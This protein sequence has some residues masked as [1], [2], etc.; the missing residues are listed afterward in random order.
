MHK[1]HNSCMFF[2]APAIYNG[3]GHIASPLSVRPSVRTYVRTYEKW[4]PGDI[5]W[6]HWCIGFIF[7]TQVYKH[8]IQVKFD[9]GQNPL[10]IIRVM[11]L[12]LRMKNGF[13]AI[14]F[15]YIDVLDSYYI[16]RYISIKYRSSSIMGKIHQSLSELWPLIS[17]KKNGFQAISFEYIG[18]LDSYFIH[19]YI[20]IEHRSSL[21][22]DKIHLLLSELWPLISI[23]KMV[24]G[25]YLLNTLV[26]WIHNSYTGI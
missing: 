23:W 5:F 10:I 3:G 8:K 25:R 26:Y 17:V 15:E 18:E 2:Y 22:M 12:D 16:H 4:F 14:S 13:R 24:S 7:H 1:S 9:Y 19:R 6:I 11:A 21:I 20:I